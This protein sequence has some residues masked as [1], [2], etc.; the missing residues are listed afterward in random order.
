M[1][2][3]PEMSAIGLSCRG[4]THEVRQ[5]AGLEGFRLLDLLHDQSGLGQGSFRFRRRGIQRPGSVRDHEE[6]WSFLETRAERGSRGSEVAGLVVVSKEKVDE[7]GLLPIGPEYQEVLD[8]LSRAGVNELS[9]DSSSW[10]TP[11]TSSSASK[12]TS[13]SRPRARCSRGAAPSSGCRRTRRPT[14]SRSGCPAR[15]R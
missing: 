7:G 6:V 4:R 12:S 2:E 5:V 13:S 9:R 15:C 8:V 1:A 14:R 11:T 10:T 3:D